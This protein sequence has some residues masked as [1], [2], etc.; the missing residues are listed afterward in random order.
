MSRILKIFFF[1]I[2]V[3]EVNADNK[4]KI[5]TNLKNTSNLSFQFEQNINGKIERG[6]CIIEYPKKIYCKYNKKNKVLVSN[7]KSLV[8][9]TLSSYYRYP[10][11]KT[12]LNLILNKNY[13]I[14][15]I[16]NLNEIIINKSYANYS[17][18]Q[19][20]I[21]IDIFFDLN[22]FDIIGWQTKDIY[23]NTATTLLDS[24]SKNIKIEKK[25]FN[26]PLQN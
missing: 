8:V 6:K 25:I 19:N 14:N 17:I 13:L 11:E 18:T 7:G 12:P 15:K 3:T 24:I 2:F 10:L 23:Q 22:S 1:L 21:K 4:E 9:K 5:L 26:L 16:Y 20:E